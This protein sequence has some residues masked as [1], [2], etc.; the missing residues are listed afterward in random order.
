MVLALSPIFVSG[1]KN[2]GFQFIL[3]FHESGFLEQAP[4]CMLLFVRLFSLI[5][6][7]NLVG[8]KPQLFCWSWKR[9][10]RKGKRRRKKEITMDGW[11]QGVMEPGTEVCVR[12]RMC[13]YVCVCACA[14]VCVRLLMSF[15]TPIKDC[16]TKD[17]EIHK[18]NKQWTHTQKQ[19]NWLWGGGRWS[20]KLSSL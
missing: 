17:T 14:C 6:L 19:D 16:S 20:V 8:L 11:E 10:G 5:C 2:A 1:T 3:E 9:L 13:M 18:H 4:V 15:L 7:F 12:K